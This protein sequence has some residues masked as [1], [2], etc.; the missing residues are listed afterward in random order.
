MSHLRRQQPQSAMVKCYM[1]RQIERIKL[2]KN[3]K[4]VLKKKEQKLNKWGGIFPNTKVNIYCHM[5]VCGVR[6]RN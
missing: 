2:H 1:V 3:R 5:V 4:E 6:T